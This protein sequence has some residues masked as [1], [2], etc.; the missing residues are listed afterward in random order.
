M[1]DQQVSIVRDDE[2]I[3]ERT[4]ADILYDCVPTQELHMFYKQLDMVPPT[5]ARSHDEIKRETAVFD[6]AEAARAI[7]ATERAQSAVEQRRTYEEQTRVINNVVSIFRNNEGSFQLPEGNLN[8]LRSKFESRQNWSAA[9]FY[10]LLLQLRFGHHGL[11]SALT[12]LSGYKG[13]T[14]KKAK[15]VLEQLR[16]Y[17]QQIATAERNRQIS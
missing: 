6:R 12:L 5:R 15:Y 4:L 8:E 10:N 9:E 3:Q 7:Q 13:E 16:V 17:E 2:S 11:K 1:L 14:G